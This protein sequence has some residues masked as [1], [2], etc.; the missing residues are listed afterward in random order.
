MKKSLIFLVVVLVMVLWIAAR[1]SQKPHNDGSYAP[2]FLQG[3]VP[4]LNWNTFMGSPSKDYSFAVAVDE[5]GNVYVTGI[6]DATWGTP[7]NGFAG[8]SDIFVAKLN[9]SGVRQWN[10]FLGAADDSWA[11]GIAVDNSGN[12]YVCGWSDSNWGTPLNPN[13]GSYDGFIAKLESSGTLQ[14]NTFIGST[15]GEDCRDIAVDASGNIYVTGIGEMNWGTPV[16]AFAGFEDAYA[17]KLNN[18][19]VLLW[20]TFMGSKD[21]EWGWGIAV[22]SSGNVYVTGESHWTWGLPVS[23]FVGIDS[24]GFV[25]KLNSNGVRQW[26]TFLGGSGYDVCYAVAVDTS[27][28]VYVGGYSD[29]N[30]GSPLNP[31]A[32]DRDAISAKLSSTGV[33][34]WNTFLGSGKDDCCSDIVVDT[35]GNVYVSGYSD[36]SWGTPAN[37]YGAGSDAFAAKLNNS[38]AYQW[39]IF[40]G[41]AGDDG[42]LSIDIDTMRNVYV[43]GSSNNS[44]GSPI[45]ELEGHYDAYVAKIHYFNVKNDFNNDGQDDILWRHYGSGA[46]ALW[47]LSSSGGTTG[48]NQR[49]IEIFSMKQ[50]TKPT[51]SYQGVFDAGEILYKDER[52]YHDAL[53]AIAP[54]TKIREN[55]YRDVREAGEALCPSGE[56]RAGNTRELKNPGDLKAEIKAISIIGI[57]YLPDLADVNWKI[58]GTGDFNGDGD[59]DILWRHYVTGANG[60]WYMVGSARIGIAFLITITDTNWRIEGTGDFNEDGNVDILWRHYVAGA[61][62][63]WYMN[64]VTLIGAVYLPTITDV[65]WKISGTGDFNGDEKVDILWRHYVTGANVLWYMNGSSLIGSTYL[66]K[67]TDTNWRIEGTGDFNKDLNLDI[68]WRHNVTG[69]NALWYMYGSTIIGV[70][71]LKKIADVNWNIENY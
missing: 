31:Y 61:N 33:L 10:T 1:V 65:N 5:G 15:K 7:I 4:A 17:A 44:W 36:S 18:S 32:G 54:D 50:R 24:D 41:G 11:T 3:F 6:S 9:S 70:E 29:S 22:D 47:Y 21:W 42:G 23:P 68:L 40:M 8:N 52:V 51:H 27:G 63:L 56:E 25:V 20:H 2:P 67:V 35:S 62:A 60:L 59:F 43:T 71:Y 12:V 28:N 53:E 55:V 58:S 26:N 69:E 16:N 38:G 66:P 30:W 46:N 19:G 13:T 57:E 48:L 49:D 45:I 39:N 37:P 64:G 14:W 34:Q